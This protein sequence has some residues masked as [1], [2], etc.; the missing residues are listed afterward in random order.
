MKTHIAL[1]AAAALVFAAQSASAQPVS[2]PIPGT[3][4]ACS[5]QWRNMVDTHTTGEM[6]RH[7][8][9]RQCVTD[10]NS[11]PVGGDHAR[12]FLFIAATIGVIAVAASDDRKSPTSP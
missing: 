2:E 12:G 10:P 11:G 8:F 1:I 7:H 6:T 9:M 4:A 3:P 5:A